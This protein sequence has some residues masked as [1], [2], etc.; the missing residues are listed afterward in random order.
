MLD[1]Q[2]AETCLLNLLQMRMLDISKS[3]NTLPS[4]RLTSLLKKN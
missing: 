2:Y 4:Q 3:L 1:D